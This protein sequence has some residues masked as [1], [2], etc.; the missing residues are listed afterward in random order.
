MQEEEE[1]VITLNISPREAELFLFLSLWSYRLVE[2]VLLFIKAS[3]SDH[4]IP[5]L[6]V[7]VSIL[8]HVRLEMT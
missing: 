3:I 7:S 5:S 4:R 1:E 2:T 6:K 8:R